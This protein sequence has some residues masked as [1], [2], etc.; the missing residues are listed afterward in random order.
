MQPNLLKIRNHIANN[1]NKPAEWWS[2]GTPLIITMGK[3][4]RLNVTTWLTLG[5]DEWSYFS[6]YISF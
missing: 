4:N 5:N 2:V 6:Y 1:R 3:T